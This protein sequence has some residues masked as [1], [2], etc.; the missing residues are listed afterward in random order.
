MM[1]LPDL[2]Q[3]V[4]IFPLPDHVLLVGLPT[5]YRV[6]E[7]RYRALV[8]DLLGREPS[9]RWLGVPRLSPGWQS[10]YEASPAFNSIAAVG[11]VR[12][13]RPL[14][15]GQFMIIIEGLIRCSLSEVESKF[16]YRLAR[17]TQRGDLPNTLSEENQATGIATV[18]RHVDLLRQR[19]GP[20]GSLFKP[21]I[22]NQSD[23]IALVDRLGAALLS[24]LDVRQ[25]FLEAQRLSERISLLQRGLAALLD[26]SDKS[27]QNWDP[28]IN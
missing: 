5:P 10:D 26:L 19:L 27:K 11:L 7:P 24:D 25:S 21:L 8:D 4:P 9:D 1:S 15:D 20:S 13:I 6:F 17:P 3:F 22:D 28:S 12:N 23:P 2:P 18:L 16:P 14:D